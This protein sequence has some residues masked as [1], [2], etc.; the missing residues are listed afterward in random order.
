LRP[1][2]KVPPGCPEDAIVL[3]FPVAREF[4][5]MRLDLFIQGRI[6]RLSR[7]RAKAIVKACAYRADGTRRRPAELV[8]FGETVLL[9]RTAFTEPDAPRDLPLLHSDELLWVIDKPA[10]LPVHPSASYHRNTVT[11]ILREQYGMKSP[12][13]T[14]RL[15]KETSGVL[16]CARDIDTERK[17]KNAF[18]TRRVQKTYLAIVRG[19]M[20][21]DDGEI[22]MPMGRPE[23]GLHLLMEVRPEGEGMPAR[24]EY[25]VLERRAGHSMVELRPLTGRQ[26]QLRVHLSAIGY[27]IVGDKLYGPE[28]EEA[29][30]EYLDTG[31]TPSLHERLGHTRHALHALRLEIAHPES[32]APMVFEAPLAADLQGIWDQLSRV[33]PRSRPA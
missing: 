18:E 30:L 28:R 2:A 1:V 14:H 9:V 3:S 20:E 7:T 11:F 15:D 16:L 27:P 33:D 21:A 5:G 23:E 22:D 10:G 32:D 6:P 31:M 17:L 4:A 24:T 26:H 12:R 8:R 29:F 25:R 13:I 19:E